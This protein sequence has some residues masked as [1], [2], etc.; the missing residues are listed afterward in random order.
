MAITVPHTPLPQRQSLASG[1]LPRWAVGLTGAVAVAAAL[2]LNTFTGVSGWFGTTL[3]GALVFIAIQSVWSF[4]VEGRRHAVDR[5]ATTL[6]Y[7][8][9]V[10]ALVPLISVIISR[11]I[12]RVSHA[13]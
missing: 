5:L 2:L 3:V 7:S 12:A 10:V 1:T 13:V 8:T 11:I 4:A 6:V 9:F